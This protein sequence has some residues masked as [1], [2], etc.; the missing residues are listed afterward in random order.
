MKNS[1][2]STV[3]LLGLTL[4]LF[5]CNSDN[6]TS[7]DDGPEEATRVEQF[8]QN[9]NNSNNELTYKIVNA[10]LTNTLV[11]DLNIST[12]SSLL[13]DE[14]KFTASN[15]VVSLKWNEGYAINLEAENVSNSVLDKLNPT[16]TSIFNVLTDSVLNSLNTN[17]DMQVSIDENLDIKITI[18][19]ANEN[20]VLVLDLEQKTS[21][22]YLNYNSISQ[23]IEIF[24]Y[25]SLGSFSDMQYSLAEN[26][27]FLYSR[28]DQNEAQF[29]KYDIS[30]GV[31]SYKSISGLNG[32]DKQFEFVNGELFGISSH[33]LATLDYDFVTEPSLFDCNTCPDSWYTTT[34]YDNEIY[35]IG[36]YGQLEANRISKFNPNTNSFETFTSLPQDLARADGKVYDDKLYVFGG[37]YIDFNQ[38]FYAYDSIFIYD[39][40]DGSL[41][42]ELTMPTY[43]TET[44]VSRNQNLIFVAGRA[45][46]DGADNGISTHS[47][48]GVFDTVNNSF[49]EIDI[50]SQFPSDYYMR[51]MAVSGDKMYFLFAV[52][53]YQGF[54]V[55]EADL[56][57]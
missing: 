34:S 10:S 23:P 36:G 52:P 8:I 2:I 46:D 17:T 47:Y 12:S 21:S 27:L 11:N 32:F 25:P 19:F 42:D 43:V 54:K 30:S 26:S 57:Q 49:Q 35:L 14:F 29:I 56:L 33:D 28:I 51:N 15:D 16:S 55:F 13:D 40:N 31:D 39:V 1:K 3:L 38:N 22:D 41:V 24:S 20:S 4:L 45:D 50:S 44:F 53:G 9:I 48:L 18:G 6:E 5:N 37:M 7:S